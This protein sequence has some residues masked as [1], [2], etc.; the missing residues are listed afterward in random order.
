[1]PGLYQDNEFDLAGFA[2]GVVNREEIIDHSGVSI[3]NRV[4]G[5]ASSGVHS[6]GFSLVRKVIETVGID[7]N[8][9]LTELGGKLSDILL[10]PTRLYSNP[11]LKLK[12]EF[13]LLGLAHITGGGLL[14]NVPRVL[15]QSA[16][17]RLDQS[18]WQPAPIFKWLAET[19]KIA[20]AEMFRVFNMGI[21]FVLIVPQKEES[22][23]LSRLNHMGET[24]YSIG[25]VVERPAGSNA[26]QVLWEPA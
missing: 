3:G 20:E 26:P 18:R 19:G 2:V 21:G 25:E 12:K 4:I 1:M 9:H 7:P 11:I 13:H 8:A 15:P 22:E 5:I 16:A 14:E 23:V 24:A 17:V 6:N 10:A